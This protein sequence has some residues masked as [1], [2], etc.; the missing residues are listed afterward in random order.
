MDD[1]SWIEFQRPLPGGGT[2]TRLRPSPVF[3]DSDEPT[4]TRG[5]GKR[6]IRFG[7][8]TLAINDSEAKNFPDRD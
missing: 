6:L 5:K 2:F 1:P 3:R 4:V 7:T 8:M